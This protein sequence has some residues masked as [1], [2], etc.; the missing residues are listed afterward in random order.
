[1]ANGPFGTTPPEVVC[2]IMEHMDD[3]RDVL[4]FAS[5]CKM[6]R[7]L[8]QHVRVEGTVKAKGAENVEQVITLLPRLEGLRV[9]GIGSTISFFSHHAQHLLE[10]NLKYTA[11]TN[12]EPLK[13]LVSLE[14]LN[15]FSTHVNN[16]EPLQGLTSLKELY[17][18]G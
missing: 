8:L 10:L 5:T 16:I 7:R 6:H 4:E 13:A 12:I 11:V 17:L 14:Y 15:L 1:M 18:G 9:T 2:I 3:P